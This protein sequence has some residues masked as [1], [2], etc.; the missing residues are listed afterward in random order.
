MP[1]PNIPRF[2]R[3]PR[4]FASYRFQRRNN[5][6]NN[7]QSILRDTIRIL[8][9]LHDRQV[10]NELV[11]WRRSMGQYLENRQFTDALQGLAFMNNL[12]NAFTYKQSEIHF[13]VLRA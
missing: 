8:E 11:Q 10:D 6:I 12:R 13:F 2:P 5:T 3:I 4:D 7:R 1:V 9:Q